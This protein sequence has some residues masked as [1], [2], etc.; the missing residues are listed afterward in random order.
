MLPHISAK[1]P[2]LAQM[3]KEVNTARINSCVQRNWA[4][5]SYNAPVLSIQAGKQQ[6]GEDIDFPLCGPAGDGGAD[7]AVR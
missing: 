4:G 1:P 7:G 3:L 6:G 5:L 2:S